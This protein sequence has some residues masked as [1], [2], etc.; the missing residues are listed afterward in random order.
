MP[1][2]GN[3]DGKEGQE[4]TRSALRRTC[5]IA[6]FWAIAC[7]YKDMYFCYEGS[8]R[9][10]FATCSPKMDYLVFYVLV[11]VDYLQKISGS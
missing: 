4:T 7:A 6:I 5:K 8:L 10:V 1:D 9:R 11:K 3:R 2:C